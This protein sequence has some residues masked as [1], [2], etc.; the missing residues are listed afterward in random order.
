MIGGGAVNDAVRIETD[1]LLT[2]AE[3]AARSDFT[4]GLAIVSPSTRTIVGPGGTADV[5][6]RVMQVLVV[7]ADAAA[8]VV[9]RGTLFDRCWG[10]VYV[11][12]DSLNR[13]IGAIRKLAGEVAGGSFEIETIPRTGYRLTGGSVGTLDADHAEGRKAEVSRRRVI[14]GGAGALLLASGGLLGS[15]R[16]R[17]ASRA[18]ARFAQ[19]I[20]QTEAAIRHED[21]NEQIIR[22]LQEAVAIR[23]DSAK[24]WGLLGFYNVILAQLS[25]PKDAAP[26]N[27]HAQEAVQRAFAIDPNEPNALL[28]MFELEGSTLDWFTRDQRL[29]RIISIDPAS[30]WAIA[31]LVLL[32]QAAGMN[33]ESRSWNERA[34][35]FAPFSL[36]FLT[37]RAFKLWIAG[38]VSEADK[39]IDQVRALYPT[40]EWVWWARFL[41]FA[42]TGR[43][44]AA[45]VMLQ[46]DPKRIGDANEIRMWRTAIPALIKPSAA[47]ISRTRQACFDVAKVDGQT[48]G[49]GVMILSELGD[50]DGAFAIAEGTLLGRGP[51][52]RTEKPGSRAA[53][54]VAAD[55]INMQWMFTPPC[56]AVRADS[57]FRPMCDGIGLTDYWRRRGVRPD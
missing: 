23:P 54:E 7:L 22:G 49:P 37:K 53:I 44:E 48:H 29:R 16:S 8:Q 33:R 52:I 1:G 21:A 28:A 5:E 20:E 4:L 57:R 50:V 9:T 51:I 40:N 27:D 30:V 45:Q 19:I 39:V 14:A 46:S 32:L 26:L 38:R 10:G 25:N 56:A 35:S 42:M 13:T 24:A 12:E 18:D 55:R 36:D 6:P 47:A 17:E 11:G 34:I 31:E 2:T 41:I 15:I 43:A 3:L